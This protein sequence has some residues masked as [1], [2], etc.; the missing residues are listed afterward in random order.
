V[1]IMDIQKEQL[2]QID[3]ENQE[4]TEAALHEGYSF[5]NED[6][7]TFLVRRLNTRDIFAFARI[8]SVGLKLLGPEFL[9]QKQE[10]TS[11][12][13]VILMASAIPLAE[14]ES[15]KL[16]ASLIGKT[17]EEFDKLPPDTMLYIVEIL[18]DHIDVKRFFTH[19]V[20]LI[21]P[22]LPMTTEEKAS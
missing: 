8:M 19:V 7:E 18:K 11:E 2:K 13:F 6:G 14:N 9:K 12:N 20:K 15:I 10:V 5:T 3:K 16:L 4:Q 21:Q 22:N 17:A 1:D